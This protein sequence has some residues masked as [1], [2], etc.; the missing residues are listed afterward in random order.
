MDVFCSHSRNRDFKTSMAAIWLN[1]VH[2]AQ[3]DKADAKD[4]AQVLTENAL[5]SFADLSAARTGYIPAGTACDSP[6]SRIRH[7]SVTTERP[8]SIATS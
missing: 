3:I 7:T 6:S 2:V 4:P 5:P 1:R 8:C